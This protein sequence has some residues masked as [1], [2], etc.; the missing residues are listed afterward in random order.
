LYKEETM[1]TH[2]RNPKISRRRFLKLSGATAVSV[3]TLAALDSVA[4]YQREA[5]AQSS[6][7]SDIQ[8][9]IG[10]FIAPVQTINGVQV[11]FG[12]IYTMFVTARLN[13]T[14][15]TTDQANLRSTLQI[16]EQNFRWSAG[17]IF[18][19]VSYGIPY[20]N[21]IGGFGSNRV[22]RRV[23]RLLANNARF[24]LEEAVPSPTDVHSS[25]PRI[26]KRRFNVPVRIEN[27]DMLFTIRGDSLTNV[28]DVR[29]W[30]GGSGR[31][32]S[33]SV[34]M[35]GNLSSIWTITSTRLMFARRSLPR[36]I[37][38]THRLSFA[39]R[40]NPESVMWMGFIDQQVAGSGPAAITTFVGN[41]SARL[42]NATA[43]SY[44]DNG[45]IQHLS[46]VIQDLEQFYAREGEAGQEEDETY[47]E[48][49]QY[50][51]RSPPPSRGNPDQF[52]EGGGPAVLPNQ[53]RGTGDAAA[54]AQGIGTDI[55]P[56]TGQHERRMG[57]LSTLQ[58]SSRAADGTPIHI[59]TDGPGFD[60]MDVP[61]G[62][63]QPKLQFSIFVPTAEF[64]RVMRANTAAQDLQEQFDVDEDE[65]GLER[66][67]TA[68]RRQNFLCPPRRNRAF[69]LVEIPLNG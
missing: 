69:P 56:D 16:I 65:N 61:G 1:G 27:N 14:P 54:T 43:G 20:F 35:P 38:D 23:P 47:L 31:L 39:S 18:T 8:F 55:D 57:H 63:E 40:I 36:E 22:A 5:L 48:R 62:S 9:N 59:R 29:N 52:A 17:G 49:V 24:A 19:F 28:T 60:N 37:A 64:F 34:P 46:H 66:F 25:N 11:Q 15:N 50:M 10:N 42:T 6:S 3:P 45:S 53:F 51:F 12:P 58:R 32:L 33:R 44:F 7:P 67:L 41:N 4:P 68:T 2:D 30:L 26:S 13:R 21:R